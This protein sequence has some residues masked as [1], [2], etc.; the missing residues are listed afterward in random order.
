MF[1]MLVDHEHH[2]S[3]Q[4]AGL[5]TQLA[6]PNLPVKARL[7]IEHYYVHDKLTLRTASRGYPAGTTH[8]LP[9][10]IGFYRSF[11]LKE[12]CLTVSPAHLTAKLKRFHC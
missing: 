12:L 8:T 5:P 11:R 4:R 9:I 7:W 6:R 3:T 1:S 10:I 2:P